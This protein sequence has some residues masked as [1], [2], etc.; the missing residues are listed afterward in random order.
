MRVLFAP[1]WREGVPY[2]S[3]LADA[4]G[5][6]GVS[7]VFPAGY[8]RGLP[9]ARICR[10]SAPDLLHLHW[11]EAY[12]APRQDGMAALR[13][14]RYPLDLALARCPHIVTAHNLFAHNL[15]AGRLMKRAALASFRSAAAVIA[16]S[17]AAARLVARTARIDRQRVAVIPHGD[18]SA[19]L[20]PPAEREAARRELGLGPG[21]VALMFGTVEPYK[22]IEEIIRLWGDAPPPATLWIV[23]RPCSEFYGKTVRSLAEKASS[24]EC[25]L[26]WLPDDALRL[27]LSAA[28]VALFNYSRILTSGAAI[29]ARSRGLPVMFPGRIDTVD[30]GE[31][32]PAV[33]RFEPETFADGLGRAV[34]AG[35]DYARAASYRAAIAWPAIAR[36]TAELYRGVL[37]R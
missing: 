8:R 3:L 13:L 26:G 32:D 14:L 25:R 1:D 21:P 22:G 4:L 33:V 31:P 37:G 12:Y 11:P 7:A 36:A 2:Q 18:V 16:H 19:R 30:L 10:E 6:A 17:D 29:L 24:V 9:V 27:W 5:A 34:A 20:G 35:A 15:G 28:D 23:G